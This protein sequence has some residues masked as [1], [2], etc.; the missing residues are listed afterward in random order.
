MRLAEAK[1]L[2]HLSVVAVAA[3]GGRLPPR[4]RDRLSRALGRLAHRLSRSKRG[5]VERNVANAFGPAARADVV[6]ATFSDF[7]R[8]LSSRSEP[9]PREG[10]PIV[11]LEHVSG[12]L[13]AGRGAILWESAGFGR[14]FLS[15]R[16]L[17]AAGIAVHQIH[18]PNNLGG[19]LVDRR[20]ESRIGACI[21]R[22][23][24]RQ[25]RRFVADIVYLPADDSLAF[26]RDLRERLARNAV[27]CC[28]GDGRV[29]QRLVPLR[30]LGRTTLFAPGMVSLAKLA[31]APLL[32][33]FCVSESD[34]RH[35]VVIEPPI[36]IER[37]ADREEELRGALGHYA[38]LLES[39]IRR[40]PELYR[41]WHLL[42]EL[43]DDREERAA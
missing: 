28:T 33:L 3:L 27:L 41:S 36:R 34:G 6:R 38:A 32:P 10:V 9:L 30:F 7:W 14:R 5:L 16:A 12:A 42:G 11:G 17:H 19:L 26:T 22:F 2:Y 25:E 31:G 4:G 1:D 8:E 21:G 20:F 18:G 40:W 24:D 29:G 35:R 43:L 39:Y 13:D 15:K 23:F 37:R